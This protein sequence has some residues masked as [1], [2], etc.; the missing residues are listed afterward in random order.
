MCWLFHVTSNIVLYSFQILLSVGPTVEWSTQ[1]RQCV[2][3][4]H[5]QTCIKHQTYTS[6]PLNPVYFLPL[7]R[8]SSDFIGVFHIQP[9]Q[10]EAVYLLNTTS[11]HYGGVKNSDP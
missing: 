7:P 5:I 10:G 1:N 6:V 11:T 8:N 9:L 2:S 3:G 4:S